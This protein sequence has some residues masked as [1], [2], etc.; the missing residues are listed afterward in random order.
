[1]DVAVTDL[2]ALTIEQAEPLIRDGE[3]SAEELVRSHLERIE[4]LNGDL[5]AFITVTADHALAEA[6]RADEDLAAGLYRGPLHGIPIGLKDI[7]HTQ[8]A[9]TTAAS[10]ILA[11]SAPSNDA[12]AVRH[13][14]VAGAIILGKANL[15]EFAYGPTS[16][17]SIC[18]AV[19]NPWNS[20]YVSGGSSGGSAAAVA[21]RMCMG[22]TGSDTGGSI[23][24]PASI[25]G[26]VGLKPTYGRVS[27]DGIIPLS[28]SLD[29]IGPMTR[30]VY[31]AAV[32]LKAMEAQDSGPGG[33]DPDLAATEKSDIG[34]L[35]IGVPANHFFED[36]EPEMERLVR[37]ALEVLRDQGAQVREVTIPDADRLS[38]AYRPIVM[39]EATAYH[40]HWLTTRPEDYSSDVHSRLSRGH[41]YSAV[42]YL[43]ARALRDE[44]TADFERLLSEDVDVLVFPTVRIS[45]PRIDEVAQERPDEFTPGLVMNTSP[46]NITGQPVVSVMC[47]LLPSG[48]PAGLSIAARRWQD[49]L[50]LSVAAAYERAAG[51][52]DLAPRI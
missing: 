50:A 41:Q 32:M 3:L 30:C 22:A 23:R 37:S 38:A 34:G 48:L 47:G 18:G 31:D 44:V 9:P 20:A 2:T 42:Q 27:L 17:S 5:R 35:R 7:F 21:A 28:P 11:A 19:R 15:H 46:F 13:L 8:E 10:K 6:T 45:P 36:V 39:A 49:S 14:R 1:M 52:T 40:E 12:L 43:R 24:I 25:C 26:I 33:V 16:T 4:R 51:W 29:H